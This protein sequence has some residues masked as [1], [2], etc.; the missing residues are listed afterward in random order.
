MRCIF[1]AGGKVIS[2]ACTGLDRPRGLQEVEAP[3]FQDSQYMRV[4]RFSAVCTGRF[5]PPGN[6]PGTHFY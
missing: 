5:Y 1:Y 3:R 6:I 2:N 4:V